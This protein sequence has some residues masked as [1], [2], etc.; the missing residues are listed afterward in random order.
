MFRKT[1]KHDP[2][3]DRMMKKMITTIITQ[4]VFQSPLNVS[5]T[6][7]EG[8]KTVIVITVT[9]KGRLRFRIENAHSCSRNL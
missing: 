8:L 2:I 9:F 7:C 4:S 1:R 6:S 3:L 5:N